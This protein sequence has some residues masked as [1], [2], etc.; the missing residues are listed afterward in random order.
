M[1]TGSLEIRNL[2]GLVSGRLDDSLHG[3]NEIRCEDGRIVALESGGDADLVIDACGAI[4]APGLIDSHAHV[5]FGD[6]TPRQSTLGWIESYMHGGVTMMMSASEVHLPGRPADR[7]GVKALAITAQRA[8]ADF[9]P[10]GVKVLA[11]SVII[12]PTLEPSDFDQMAAAGVK[13]AKVGFGDFDKPADA[14]PLV[15]AAQAAGMIVMNHTG[16]ASIP[17]SRPVTAEDCITLG[18]D[19]IGHANGGP[20]SLPDG[21][22]PLLFDAAG[23]IQLVQ[24]GNLRSSLLLLELARERGAMERIVIATD[25]PTGTGVMPLGMIKTVTEL[26]SLGG[27][28]ASDSLA[29]ATGNNAR[30][31]RREEGILE[32]GRPADFALLEPPLGGVA[33]NALAAIE[34]GDLPGI[35][36]VVIDG[37]L[38]ALRSRNAPASTNPA[39]VISGSLP[40]AFGN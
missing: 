14:A 23:A 35:S 30:V 21:D 2:G 17:G 34:R 7:E 29:M 33:D 32:V 8:F 3:V 25:T 39:A 6:W 5:V 20:T 38:R 28:S 11:G 12:E 10:G 26:S 19:F 24:A 27:I 9:R 4:A 18:C 15:R 13:L 16:G 22:L 40:A 1:T 37:A 31:L 36:A